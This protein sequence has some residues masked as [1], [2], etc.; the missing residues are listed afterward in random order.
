M[1]S[2]QQTCVPCMLPRLSHQSARQRI[3]QGGCSIVG[4]CLLWMP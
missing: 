3:G 1:H 4:S 2:Q